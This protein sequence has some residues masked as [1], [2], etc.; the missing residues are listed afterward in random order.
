MSRSDGSDRTKLLRTRIAR[1]TRTRQ[2]AAGIRIVSAFV[3]AIV[4]EQQQREDG[5][6]QAERDC[7]HARSG[8]SQKR[9]A[10]FKL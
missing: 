9:S 10:F 4:S 7:A 2:D 1:L 6:A 5:A 8:E 3:A